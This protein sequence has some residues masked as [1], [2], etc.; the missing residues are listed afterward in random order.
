MSDENINLEILMKKNYRY[1]DP[2]DKNFQSK[3]YRKRE[4]YYNRL[5]N[6][7]KLETYQDIKEVRDTVCS[8]FTSLREYQLFLSNFINPDTPYK[9]VLVYHG[10]GS[11]KTASAI[12]IAEK[13]KDM[14][15]KYNTKIYVLVNGPIIKENWKNELILATGETYLKIKDKNALIGDAE[16]EKLKK[17][18]LAEAMQYYK[19]ISYRS[20]YKKVL[21]EKIAETVIGDDQKVKKKYRKTEDGQYERDISVDRIYDLDN[22]LIIIDE[23]HNLTGNFYGEAL[24]KIIKNSKNLKVVLLTAT[25]MKN[26]ADDIIELVNFLRPVDMPMMRD[27]IFTSDKNYEMD[28]KEGGLEYLKNMSRGYISHLRGADPLTFATMVEKGKIAPGLKFTRITACKMKPW[29]KKV[30]EDITIGSDDSLDRNSEAVANFVFPG[31]TDNRKSLVGLHGNEGLN[32]VLNQLKNNLEGLNKRIAIDILKNKELEGNTDLIYMSDI[33]KNITGK[34]LH[35]DHLEHFSSKFYRAL[36]NLNRLYWGDKG[37]RIAFVYSNLVK[38]GVE[39][40]QE[41]L[42]QNGYLEYQESESAYIINPETKCYYCGKEFKDHQ[43]VENLNR[44]KPSFDFETENTGRPMY[45]IKGG[46][47]GKAPPPHEF[48]PAT[49]VSVTGKSQDEGNEVIPEDKVRILSKIYN[50]KDNMEGKLIKFVLGSK[51]MHEGIS[52]KNVAEVHILDVYYNLGKVEQVKG[53]GIRHCSHYN[54]M[55]EE[56]PYP[57]VNVY[58][59]SIDLD[60]GMSSEINLYRKAEI[61]HLLVKRVERA[62]KEVSIDCPLNRVWKRWK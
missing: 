50:S 21:G 10:T 56:N 31:L 13:F 54:F 6:R 48:H 58:K 47:K 11:G 18:A 24:K 40:F 51:V 32:L 34:I 37:S 7:D 17:D 19:F 29:Q 33:S 25:P 20:F 43:R 38:I 39:L 30:Y 2:K 55:T 1:P 41:I 59:Y 5:S 28:F 22:T 8:G 52:L 44:G 9:G 23:A 14:V 60:K 16:M 27:K 49:F 62:L 46:K 3:I 15:Q 57:K 61:K 42:I 35:L 12:A 4:F 45:I 36:K 26:L 53:R